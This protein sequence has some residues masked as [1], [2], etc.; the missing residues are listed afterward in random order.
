MT[1]SR[2]VTRLLAVLLLLA[3]ILT[4]CGRF[5][6][7]KPSK[8]TPVILISIDTLRSDHLP[9]Y[10]YTGVQTPNIDALRAD[11]I[12]YSRAYSHVPLTLPSHASILTGMLPADHGVRDN[13]GYRL[14]DAVPTL[15]EL[16]AKNGYATG[17]AVSAFVLR[18]ET[19]IARGFD[20][21]DDD[22]KPLNGENLIGRVQRDGG[23]TLKAAEKWL[24]TQGKAPFF[25]F[26]HLYDP[27]TPYTPP[28]PYFSRYE[29]HYDG[30]IAYA[31]SVVGDLI[32]DLK[33]SGV[34]DDA[35]IILLSDHGEGLSEHGEEEHG[36]FLY[37]EALQVPL[38]VK[39]P[40]QRK[41][42][43]TVDSPVQ[44]VDVFPTILE[45]T[46][47]PLPGKAHRIGQSLLTF[48]DHPATRPVYS[49]TYYPRFHFGWSD[50]HSLIDG[51]DHYIRSVRPE[52]YDLASDPSEKKNQL[53]A[54]RRS[55]VRLRTAIEPF[56]KEAEAPANIDPE[57]AAKL[58]ALGYVGS[59][60]AT[61]SGETLPDPKDMVGVF[62]DIRLAYTY[63]RN[64]NE[65]EALKLTEQLLA[66]NGRIT[67]LWD[68]KTKILTKMGDKKGAVEA[69]KDGLRHVPG[70][71]ALLFDVASLSLDIGDLDAAQQH[72]EIAVKIEPGQA[73]DILAQVWKRR[74]NMEK[75]EAEAKLAAQT[76]HDPTDALIM[77]SGI[78]NKRGDLQKALSYLDRA[79][80]SNGRSTT[81]HPGLHSARG[82]L[83]A[84]LN[85]NDEAE[86]EFRAEIQLNP[87]VPD[88]YASLVMLLAVEH[89]LDEGTKLIFEVVKNAPQPHT[90]TVVAETL[91]AIGDDGGALFW[92]DQGQKLYPQDAELKELPQHI[93][94]A[95]PILRQRLTR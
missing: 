75:A 37:R 79:V 70:A 52:L 54:N 10:G 35:M 20:F 11:S 42:G 4:A 85:R 9:A 38:M 44:L 94:K 30:E 60:V 78:E 47:T 62:H 57:D 80:E 50:L 92:A 65:P 26:L 19:G 66:S 3:M 28:E 24:G 32:A 55:T 13:V 61:K 87:G 34:Y 90:Y 14:S 95:A 40:Q 81:K 84:R 31:D 2:T 16:L 83:L 71:I 58:A 7:G 89:R 48:L 8:S 91:T 74:G 5:S 82:D 53:D 64:N 6:I 88:P 49:E 15:Q 22:V 68:L 59:T 21:F 33:R 45:R 63:F 69:A 41:K 67:D 73:H 72:A 12:L 39:L 51:N 23:N 1:W 25:F 43:A 56:V 36:I 29:N 93:R 46:A 17:A 77:L 27:H 76:T 18:R 86:K